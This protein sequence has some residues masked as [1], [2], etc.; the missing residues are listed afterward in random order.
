MLAANKK[1]AGPMM[2]AYGAYT[3]AMTKA[4]AYVG[5]NRLQPTGRRSTEL[6]DV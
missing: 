2:S 6:D 5:G 4:G 1:T 3:D